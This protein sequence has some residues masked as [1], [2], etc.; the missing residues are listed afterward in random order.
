MQRAVEPRRAEDQVVGPLLGVV[1]E[2]L[3]RLV[4]LLIVDDEHHRV[5]DEAGDGD[6]IVARE[7]HGTAEQLVDLGEAG[8]RHDVHEQ[9]VAVGLGA[10]G[11]L[12]A[13][14][15]GRAGLG[16]DHHRLLEDRL[17]HRRQRP[18]HHV[19]GA[20]GRE[21][22]DEGDGAGGVDL[23][24]MRGPGCQRGCGGGGACD[25]AASVHEI[26][27]GSR[28]GT[29][30]GASTL[31]GRGRRARIVQPNGSQRPLPGSTSPSREH[32]L[33]LRSR[34]PRLGAAIRDLAPRVEPRRHHVG[35]QD[36]GSARWR[37]PAGDA[38][39]EDCAH[40]PRQQ[41]GTPPFMRPQPSAPSD[42]AHRAG[43]RPGC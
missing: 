30:L 35:Q 13:D 27:P 7:L 2:L 32:P 19:D 34:K 37:A 18:R 39:G 28:A 24:R 9:R 4:G 33:R 3:Q 8:D 1:D 29:H 12:G 26:L 25:E 38:R 16:L 6:E 22:V 21:R 41:V 43:R 17:Q 14:L 36:P 20:A 5:G 10:G 23:L 42:P 40:S 11:E 31:W 15:A